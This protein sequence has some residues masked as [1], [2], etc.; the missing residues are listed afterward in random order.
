[1]A[2]QRTRRPSL[3]SGRSLRSLGSP[4]NAY[5]LGV[6]RVSSFIDPR[7][8]V[9]A[10]A[11]F[12]LLVSSPSSA[13]KR[14][15]TPESLT[16]VQILDRVSKAYA[17]CRTYRDSGFVQIVFI[18]PDRKWSEKKVF[19][20]A[21]DRPDRF[22]FE[23]KEKQGEDELRY[24]VWR[25]GKDVRTWWDVKPGVERPPSL[26]LALAGATGV[27]GGS[28]HTVPALLLPDEVGGWQLTSMTDVRRIEDAKLGEVDCFRVRG[29]YVEA[30]ATVWIEKKTFLVRRIDS[31]NE[32]DDFRTEETTVYDPVVDGELTDEMLRFDPP[33]K[34][35]A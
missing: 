25:H 17:H 16:A 11:L 15:P 26:G 18:R 1:M 4:L 33:T 12:L 20:T 5:P 19:S 22:R 10:L 6:R 8:L 3:R 9:A 14:R 34:A 31:G 27:S 32:F 7:C 28:A 23:Y 2:L 24:L 13:V 21:F 35:D 30:Q 29:A